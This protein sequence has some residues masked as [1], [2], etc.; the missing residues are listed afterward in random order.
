MSLVRLSGGL[1][2]RTESTE[3]LSSKIRQVFIQAFKMS[4]S[5]S[6]SDGV[7]MHMN[8]SSMYESTHVI[9]LVVCIMSHVLLNKVSDQEWCIQ[10]VAYVLS[11]GV[12]HLVQVV[13]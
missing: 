3:V 8:Q 7:Q 4:M 12:R 2:H 13:F 1:R 5:G 10:M 11:I 9:M 6:I